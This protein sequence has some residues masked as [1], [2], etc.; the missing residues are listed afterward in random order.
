MSTPKNK[1]AWLHKAGQDLQVNTAPLPEAGQGEIIVKNV[2]I[3]INPLDVYM[4]GEG[5]FVQ[6]WPVVLGCDVAGEVYQ[7]GPGVQRFKKGDRVVGH[8]V[9]LTHGRE[10][11][12]AY[13][14]Y[15]AVLE[16][17]AALIPENVP[18]KDAVVIPTAL[19]SAVCA[20][21]IKEATTIMPGVQKGALGLPSASLE[22]KPRSIG[23][24]LVVYGG[25]T[26]I[27]FMTTQLARAA[28]V[29]VIAIG[30]K[31]S[32]QLSKQAGASETID[33]KDADFTDKVVQAVK[34][35]GNT[36]VG[37]FDAPSNEETYANDLKILE[38]LNGGHLVC[39]HPPPSEV[40]G[41]VTTGMIF[42]VDPAADPVW[43]D[44]VTPALEKG[45]IQCLPKPNVVGTGLEAIS[46]AHGQY[47]AGVKAEKLVVE[48]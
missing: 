28:G 29:D 41:N 37:I 20:L 23:K 2:A 44:F 48:L 36:F 39:S 47:K 35:K 43:K 21:N 16:N 30:S 13:A 24:T 26:A 15:T 12:G 14:L 32:A 27:G 7:V 4:A 38:K 11:D 19:E 9:L 17:K 6:R 8:T 40:P 34:A 22:A 25:N 45:V 5:H 10:Q 46:K 42:A 31:E 33:Y 1:A 18:F 3:S